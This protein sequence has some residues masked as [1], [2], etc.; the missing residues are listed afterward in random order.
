[1][2]DFLNENSF[3][4]L[5]AVITCLVALFFFFTAKKLTNIGIKKVNNDIGSINEELNLVEKGMVIKTKSLAKDINDTVVHQVSENKKSMEDGFKK[6]TNKID[7]I[8]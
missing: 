8:K 5:M 3:I 1:M 4:I 7:N 2:N 6:I